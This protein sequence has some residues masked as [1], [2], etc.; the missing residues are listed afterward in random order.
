MYDDLADTVKS[1]D[2]LI[3]LDDVLPPREEAGK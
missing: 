3:F 2:C 1:E